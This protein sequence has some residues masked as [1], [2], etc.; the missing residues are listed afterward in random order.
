[1]VLCSDLRRDERHPNE[2]VGLLLLVGVCVMV[3]WI[4]KNESTLE[5]GP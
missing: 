2:E 1:M 5:M 4:F 3:V